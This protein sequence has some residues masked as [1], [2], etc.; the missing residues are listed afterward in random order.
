MGNLFGNRKKNEIEQQQKTNSKVILF[1]I[2]YL[3]N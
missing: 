1:L 3:R 2:Y